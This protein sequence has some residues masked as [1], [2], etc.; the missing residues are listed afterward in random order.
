MREKL[1]ES[2]RERVCVC[3]G[4]CERERER[5]SVSVK[6]LLTASNLR[7]RVRKRNKLEVNRTKGREKH[8]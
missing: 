4:V 1:E 2:E 6:K 7:N 5:E 3:V 8:T